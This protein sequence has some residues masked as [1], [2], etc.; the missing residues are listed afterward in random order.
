MNV[1]QNVDGFKAKI[2][3]TAENPLFLAKDI[4]E[5]LEIKN[6]RDMLNNIDDDEKLMSVVSTSGQNRNMW[7]LTEDG[8][9][10]VLMQSR[11]QQAKLFKKKVKETMKTIRKHGAYMTSEVIEKT[12]TSPDFII[13]LATQLKTEQ[14]KTAM[15]SQQVA[16][17]RPKADYY[18]RILKS[19]SLV[20]IS[21]I[22]DDYGMTAQ[23]LNK[24]LFELQIQHKVG[25]QWLL[26]A[27]HKNH[28]YTFS[29][30]TI[31]PNYKKGGEK[32][33]MNTKW[34]QKG[35]IFIYNVLKSEGILPTIEKNDAA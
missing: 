21:Q 6:N 2:Y 3:G 23:A 12:L 15:L 27:K 31:L 9:Y 35:R 18:D 30:T 25:G 8:L 5:M 22:A 33:V 4:A 16:E 19:K 7:F 1:L 20:T 29:D 34:T 13:Q 10:E 11:K 14:E 17:S 32:V 24:K 28:G 26:Y